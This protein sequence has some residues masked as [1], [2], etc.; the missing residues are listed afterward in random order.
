MGYVASSLYYCCGNYKRNH[1]TH[2]FLPRL[3]RLRQPQLHRP[4]TKAAAV[5]KMILPHVERADKMR[6]RIFPAIG[7]RGR[8]ASELAYAK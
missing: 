1:N 8:F 5:L 2:S 3:H 7:F 6:Q 4:H